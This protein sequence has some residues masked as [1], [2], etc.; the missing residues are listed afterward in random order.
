M[1][2]KVNSLPG[3]EH[4]TTRR[5]RY[6]Q[7]RRG[8]RRLDVSG[9]VVWALAGVDEERV[10]FRDKAAEECQEIAL[11]VGIGVFL[12][13]ER[14]RGV[15][16]EHGQQAGGHAARGD[17]GLNL[18]CDLRQRLAAGVNGDFMLSLAHR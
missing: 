3:S 2:E 8:Q 5:N 10:A 15:S 9:H 7:R 16:H 17:E 13:E 4:R 11:H 18:T 14:R 1:L 12:D 6:R